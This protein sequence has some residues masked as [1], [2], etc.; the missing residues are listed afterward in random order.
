MSVN[1]QTCFIIGEGIL[2]ILCGDILIS[3]NYKVLGIRSTDQRIETWAREN[4]IRFI[5][6]LEELLSILRE[7]PFDFLFS[8]S[9]LT[10]LSKEV[11][12][13]PRKYAINYHNG[14]LPRYAGL[15]VTSWALINKEPC[16]G[17]TWHC[18]NGIIDGGDIL[19]QS[20]L[21]IDEDE[22][23][24]SLDI[25][26]FES[27]V[28]EFNALTDELLNG[29]EVLTAQNLSQRT[30]FSKYK[31]LPSLA[32]ITGDEDALDI[33][34][35]IRALTFENY[36]N[37][38][39]MPKILLG[40]N[41]YV[42][43]KVEVSFTGTNEE[44]GVIT[45]VG[46]NGIRIKCLRNEI[47][48]TSV[49]TI[50][51]KVVPIVDV[52]ALNGLVPG[53][54]LEKLKSTTLSK[55]TEI[56]KIICM[57]ECYWVNKLSRLETVSFPYPYLN[58]SLVGSQTIS[59]LVEDIRQTSL[60]PETY[61]S[62]IFT[63]AALVSFLSRISGNT[64]FD[65]G[66][67]DSNIRDFNLSN[68]FNIFSEFVPLHVEFDIGYNIHQVVEM[69][70]GE[71][72]VIRKAK[73][74][75]N[76]IFLRYPELSKLK[77]HASEGS[78]FPI[79]IVIADNLVGYRS[80]LPSSV[81][82]TFTLSEIDHRLCCIYDNTIHSEETIKR[83]SSQFRYYLSNLIA[84]AR[85][86]ITSMS[87]VPEYEKYQL[88]FE[89]N[90]TEKPY[91][92][93]K[94]INQLFEQQVNEFPDKIAIQFNEEQLTF[95]DLNERSNQ[96]AR[97]IRRHY[98]TLLG[99]D[100]L[101]DKIVGMCLNNCVELVVGMLAILKSGA[102]YV[103][104]DPSYPKQ[105]INYILS[106]TQALIILTHHQLDETHDFGVRPDRILH[107]DITEDFYR[108]EDSTD[109][110]PFS[111][112]SNLA[113]VIY[114]SGTSG[115]PKGI[116]VNHYSVN[117]EI[118]SQLEL[119]PLTSSM[120]SL[121]TS[122]IVFDAAAECIYM[123]LFSGGC[124]HLLSKE[125]VLDPNYID[126][127]VRD[128][129]I[130]VLNT[131]PSY[132]NTLQIDL[133]ADYIIFII[134]GG[135]PFQKISS[136][137][138][139]YNTYGPTETTI[140]A[141]ATKVGNDNETNIGKPINNTKVYVLDKFENL[142]PIG[143]VG[144]LH[145]SGA[146]VAQGYLNNDSLTALKFVNNPFSDQYVSQGHQRL[147]KTGDLVRWRADGNLEYVGRNDNQIKI[148]GYRVEL[149][150]IEHAIRMIPGIKGSCVLVKEKNKKQPSSK[151]LVGYYTLMDA[152]KPVDSKDI[153][154]QIS[155]IMPS[156]MIPSTL[157]LMD[158][159]PLTVNGKVNV[160]E[161]PMPDFFYP[162]TLNFLQATTDLEATLCRIWQQVLV[163]DRVGITDDFFK[164]GGNSIL[165]MKVVAQ[166]NAT[167]AIK[168]GV[169]SLLL[170]TTI[171]SIAQLIRQ[172]QDRNKE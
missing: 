150:E 93:D 133:Y 163:V 55:I 98:H 153:L 117:N 138:S 130:N 81:N 52:I 114:T 145:I 146:G 96:L 87:L 127:Y 73:T 92:N 89:W 103:A 94:T 86:P 125:H 143:V 147:Y 140:V 113:Y 68:P 56:D 42:I 50:E 59:I 78:L 112:G 30:Y 44:R 100:L 5:N 157:V 1:G 82:I 160:S 155:D 170:N 124:L 53:S 111:V 135:E 167:L 37:V 121:L 15:N 99:I 129:K 21:S 20:T 8:I 97:K 109:L 27:A 91:P 149:G 72:N 28:N 46:P 74:F 17:I 128:F 165:L 120:S 60:F 70:I 85:S 139:I 136:K 101:P 126:S 137:A 14:P 9:N 131:T 39:G 142:L 148:H 79:N 65:I 11:Y 69:L 119:I 164:I 4:N 171:Q 26:C 152:N 151:Y 115:N 51:G 75:S 24:F 33:Y 116:M 76:D 169:R 134:V 71:V 34:A 77:S 49:S 19:K 16:Y 23:V 3:K 29:T 132:L 41:Y 88:L 84:N 32:I 158:S 31:R 54:K 18:I 144:E 90:D 105:R 123:S 141:T 62:T 154:K 63:M 48:I 102:A 95:R 159:F 166:I 43:L 67:S 172:T 80:K 12:D 168:L 40:S 25:K 2:P 104:I 162:S 122:N 58:S 45:E 38:L 156:Y 107:I 64:S 118:L 35:I 7:Q 47:F 66:F 61:D 6:Q 161:F 110:S 106:D 57:Q 10:L 108:N 13:S 36:Q 83:M 22:T